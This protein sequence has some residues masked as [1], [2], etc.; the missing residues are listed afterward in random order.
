MSSRVLRQ[1][2]LH[3]DDRGADFLAVIELLKH[4]RGLFEEEIHRGEVELC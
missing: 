4:F 3:L 1:V 2:D